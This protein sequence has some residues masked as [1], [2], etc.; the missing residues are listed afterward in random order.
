MLSG[1]TTSKRRRGLRGKASREKLPAPA[2][3]ST[4][5]KSLYSLSTSSSRASTPSLASTRTISKM[6]HATSMTSFSLAS[7]S[8]HCDEPIHSEIT[9]EDRFPP[10]PPS[11]R[12]YLPPTN[13]VVPALSPMEIFKLRLAEGTH[14]R[15]GSTM[16]ALSTTPVKVVR[17]AGR[18]GQGSRPRALSVAAQAPGPASV[19]P[20]P[21]RDIRR[22][23]FA[24]SPSAQPHRRTRRPGFASPGIALIRFTSVS[25]SISVSAINLHT[26]AA[27]TQN[28]GRGANPGGA[29]PARGISPQAVGGG[30][31][32][33]PRKVKPQP[34][35]EK[36]EDKD[37]KDQFKFPWKGKG[38]AKAQAAAVDLS[39]NALTRTD[40]RESRFSTIS[41]IAFAPAEI[42]P[43]QRPISPD[44]P[45]LM[46]PSNNSVDSFEAVH[47]AKQ[48]SSRMSKLTRTLGAEFG[49]FSNNLTGNGRQAQMD[50]R[51][52]NR[53]SVSV[54]N[55]PLYSLDDSIRQRSNYGS[56]MRTDS[57]TTY[58]ST[59]HRREVWDSADYQPQVYQVRT[60]DS[61]TSYYPE[62]PRPP[63]ASSSAP[64]PID[65]DSETFEDY[66]DNYP[67]DDVSEILS[68]PH[69]ITTDDDARYSLSTI[70]MS[71]AEIHVQPR[72]EF[73]F[74][75]TDS[76]Y[77]GGYGEYGRTHTPTR[78]APG[79]SPGDS[80][81]GTPLPDDKQRFESPFQTMPLFVVPWEPAHP[82]GDDLE[83]SGEWNQKD[84]QSVIQSLRTLKFSAD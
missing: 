54:P 28:S 32:S 80:R 33:R 1:L 71:S 64:P 29:A 49:E 23:I 67:D 63:Q 56:L 4:S 31:G 45:P 70:S 36:K 11:Q 73:E 62:A 74:G 47:L 5:T 78:F 76:E 57:V 46:P 68:L 52:A 48:Q 79:S 41:S 55:A 3:Q 51:T 16:S 75:E 6:S 59:D 8:S 27:A 69:T 30:A 9:V 35:P 10:P 40:T 19:M 37:G 72:F 81:G 50:P 83:W 20:L 26:A 82:A 43:H 13:K 77:G 14:S 2:P 22:S 84:M 18:G 17:V 25:V 53:S 60:T 39:T 65:D 61:S 42:Q 21:P 15:K 66:I 44:P 34:P 38:K 7:S 58:N 12:A 24:P